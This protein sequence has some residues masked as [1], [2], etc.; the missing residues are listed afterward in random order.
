MFGILPGPAYWNRGTQMAGLIEDEAG[1]APS[2]GFA[3]GYHLETIP[4]GFAV[5]GAV[6]MP[7]EYA[8]DIEK[9]THFAGMW[10]CGED[11]PQAKN[12]ITRDTAK[13][14]KFGL[15]FPHVHYDD[16][17]MTNGCAITRLLK[18]AR[19]TSRW[20][21]KVYEAM[22]FASSHNMGSCRMSERP[23]DG[24]CNKWGQSHEIPNLFISDG[25]QFSTSAAP[26]PT[27][28]IVA[29][30]IRQADYIADQMAKRAI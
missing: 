16:T 24:V 3:G 15:A 27:L 14:D 10:I 29:L 20:A 11:L 1:H 5:F 4:V 28:T 17:S 22:P 6:M 19:S 12:R 30:T 13:K 2:R 21:E 23:E 9:Y 18:A 8:R 26:N 25:S 7:G